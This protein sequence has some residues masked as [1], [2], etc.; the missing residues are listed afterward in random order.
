MQV[1]GDPLGQRLHNSALTAANV[2]E[3]AWDV[4]KAV[5]LPNQSQQNIVADLMGHPVHT[6]AGKLYLGNQTW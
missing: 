2:T 6:A 3:L 5:E 1:K 4:D